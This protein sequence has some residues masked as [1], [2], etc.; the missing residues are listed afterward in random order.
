[1]AFKIETIAGITH[2]WH[3]QTHATIIK[4]RENID[5]IKWLMANGDELEMIRARFDNVPITKDGICLWAG[6]L[7]DFIFRN[8]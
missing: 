3:I 8:L 4:N 1:M 7:A 2:T 6:E 5:T